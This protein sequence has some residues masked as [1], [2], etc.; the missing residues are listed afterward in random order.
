MK[1]AWPSASSAD[2]AVR[3]V[4]SAVRKVTGGARNRSHQYQR[5]RGAHR[6]SV[7]TPLPARLAE[8]DGDALHDLLIAAAAR[9]DVAHLE[10]GAERRLA[11]HLEDRLQGAAVDGLR[12]AAIERHH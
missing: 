2:P 7:A 9:E 4:C 1:N 8:V 6:V 3:A 12:R 5:T 10:L 11:A